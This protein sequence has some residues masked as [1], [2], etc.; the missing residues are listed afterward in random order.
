[1]PNRRF[2]DIGGIGHREPPVGLRWQV[3]PAGSQPPGRGALTIM[4]LGL[5][6]VKGQFVSAAVSAMLLLRP[7]ELGRILL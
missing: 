1:M 4:R 3:V 2:N 6:P 5:S 7:R